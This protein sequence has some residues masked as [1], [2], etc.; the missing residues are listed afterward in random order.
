MKIAV[1]FEQEIQT[2]GGYQQSLGALLLLKNR[3]LAKFSC[4]S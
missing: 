2:G 1:I 4:L 3:Q